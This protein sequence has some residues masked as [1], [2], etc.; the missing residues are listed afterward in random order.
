MTVKVAML[1]AW[2]RRRN[3]AYQS[4]AKKSNPQEYLKNTTIVVD[5]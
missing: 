2:E 4:A 3:A 1:N 5:N